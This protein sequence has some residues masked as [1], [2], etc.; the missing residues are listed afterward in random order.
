MRKNI[1]RFIAMLLLTSLVACAG[2]KQNN[3]TLGLAC[4]QDYSCDEG[5]KCYQSKCTLA[6]EIPNN[7]PDGNNAPDGTNNRAEPAVADAGNNNNKP[8]A[9]VSPEP[10]PQKTYP[11]GPYG[12]DVN[13]IMIP[14]ELNNCNS[15][16]AGI[17]LSDLFNDPDIKVIQL[18]VHT[19]WCPS[20]KVQAQGMEAFYQKYKAKGLAI[21]YIMTE[22]GNA[23]GGKISGAYCLNHV[24]KYNFTF[25]SYRDEGSQIMRKFF[26]R[27]AVPLNMII[28]TK[29]MKIRYKKAGALPERMEGI[30]ASYL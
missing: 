19:G 27:N 2:G 3:G 1:T 17:K 21:I 6:S 15:T 18:T 28:T 8:D 22:D 16:G 24:K 20:C 12:A 25:A 26:D 14:I 4:Q 30:I 5:Q 29:D 7:T 23:G 13:Q 10:P 9:A 11:D